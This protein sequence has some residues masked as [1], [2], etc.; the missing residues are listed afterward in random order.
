MKEHFTKIIEAIG[1]D[2]N[3]PGLRDT[4]ERAA[5]AL[6]FL[7]RGYQQNVDDVVNDAL[8]PSDSSEMIISV[9]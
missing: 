6:E 1:E 2:I 9:G 5:K 7:T 4:P 3:R 8:F